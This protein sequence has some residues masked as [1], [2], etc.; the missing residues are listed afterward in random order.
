MSCSTPFPWLTCGK[1][2]TYSSIVGNT[3]TMPTA[4]WQ[5]MHCRNL[6][7]HSKAD[8]QIEE[9]SVD[10]TAPDILWRK[11]WRW[12]SIQALMARRFEPR[13]NR[14]KHLLRVPSQRNQ[15][16]KGKNQANRQADRLLFVQVWINTW[17]ITHLQFG[18]PSV[19]LWCS[20]CQWFGSSCNPMTMISAI[21]QNVQ[22]KSQKI[23]A[24]TRMGSSPSS[25]VHCSY[26]LI[27]LDN[28][29]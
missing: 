5:Q 2:C 20:Q 12:Q 3:N 24:L 18:Q 16:E 13:Q 11:K 29:P 7:R 9:K 17:K 28:K 10:Q 23:K 19:W 8:Q 15:H 14:A 25:S 22:N 1:R 6:L 21:W 26:E 27:F 4:L